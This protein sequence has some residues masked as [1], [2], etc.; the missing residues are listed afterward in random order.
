[1][2]RFSRKQVVI[3]AVAVA[4]LV[5]QWPPYLRYHNP[6]GYLDPGDHVALNE[7]FLAMAAL[8]AFIFVVA[9]LTRKLDSL[10]RKSDE[11]SPGSEAAATPA[12]YRQ[13]WP[14]FS[15]R[16]VFV[17][18]TILCAALAYIVKEARVIAARRACLDW[19]TETQ[20]DYMG[21]DDNIYTSVPKRGGRFT[22]WLR[23]EG[24][25]ATTVEPVAERIPWLRRK[26]GDKFVHSIGL[27]D[28]SQLARV[29][30]LFPEATIF[31]PPGKAPPPKD[32]QS[33]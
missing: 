13:R 9:V 25:G 12:R 27:E 19:L 24:W 31:L 21:W 14:R 5:S 6:P 8:E 17:V 23:N 22:G 28:I 33:P 30:A 29:Q 3:A 4:A 18:V 7:D 16:T 10:G 32:L 20:H 26:L 2:K 15:L 11:P 1:M